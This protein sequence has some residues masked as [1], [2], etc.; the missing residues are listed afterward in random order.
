[1]MSTPT[2][3]GIMPPR[4]VGTDNLTPA[5]IKARRNEDWRIDFEVGHWCYDRKRPVRRSIG[6]IAT[7]AGVSCRTVKRGI[8]DAR[9]LRERLAVEC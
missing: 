9:R 5:Q 6:L 4:T 3:E 7:I 1:M 8:A 2:G